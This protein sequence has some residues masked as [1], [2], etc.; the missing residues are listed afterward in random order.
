MPARKRAKWPLSI[1]SDGLVSVV[2]STLKNQNGDAIEDAYAKY[3]Q[4]M[5]I[6]TPRIRHVIEEALDVHSFR[7]LI[8]YGLWTLR[9]LR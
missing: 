8:S 3:A 1:L 6:F 4:A 9:N 5:K 2:E 7:E